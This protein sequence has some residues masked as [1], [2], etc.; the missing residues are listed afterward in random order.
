MKLS[1]FIKKL[2]KLEAEGHGELE[3]R[4]RHGASG[5]CGQLGSAH[6]TDHTDDQGPFDVNGNYVSI[7]VGH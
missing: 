5:M 1:D 4:Y 3:V 7:Y 6:V 2:Q